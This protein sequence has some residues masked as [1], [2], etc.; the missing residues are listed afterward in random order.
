MR[1]FLLVAKKKKNYKGRKIFI[2]AKI[3]Q[4]ILFLTAKND[5]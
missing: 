1:F 3:S 5:K 2:F 4:E